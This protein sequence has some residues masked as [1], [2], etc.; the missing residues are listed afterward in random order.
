[1]ESKI[2]INENR[3]CTRCGKLLDNKNINESSPEA[4]NFAFREIKL[5]LCSNCIKLIKEKLPN[6]RKKYSKKLVSLHNKY[7]RKLLR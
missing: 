6:M 7:F 5:D 4:F 1:M 2:E 3:Y